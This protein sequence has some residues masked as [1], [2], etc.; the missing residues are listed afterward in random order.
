VTA[1]NTL[2][3]WVGFYD[4][5]KNGTWQW[6]D[7]SPISYTNWAVGEPLGVGTNDCA[8]FGTP[9]E[10]FQWH[11]TECTDVGFGI[12]HADAQLQDTQDFPRLCNSI[13]KDVNE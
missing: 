12:C 1:F 10:S 7:G 8:I 9:D 4:P 5:H 13:A 3:I 6:K 11:A 2:N